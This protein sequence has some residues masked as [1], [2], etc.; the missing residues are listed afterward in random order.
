MRQTLYDVLFIIIISLL[1]IMTY[2]IVKIFGEINLVHYNTDTILTT[3][4]SW[5]L[6]EEKISQQ[7]NR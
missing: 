5:E 2:F 4:N 7:E 1:L 3:L 6:D